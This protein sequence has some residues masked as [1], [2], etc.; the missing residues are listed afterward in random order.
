MRKGAKATIDVK[1]TAI[2]V[3]SEEGGDYIS[4][5]DIARSKNPD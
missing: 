3:R 2:A 4:L 5:T 1:G